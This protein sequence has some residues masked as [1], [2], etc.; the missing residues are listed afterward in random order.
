[1]DY[2]VDPLVYHTV[3]DPQWLDSHRFWY[4]DL[5]PDGVTYTLVDTAKRSKAPAFDHAKIAAALEAAQ[6]T[7]KLSLPANTRLDPA[8]LPIDDLSI[9]DGDHT[10]V[11]TIGAKRIRCELRDQ[12]VCKSAGDVL[13][14]TFDVAPDG[15]TA[16]FIRDNNLWVRD[17][18]TGRETQLTQDG[19]AD[20]GYATDNAGWTRSGRPILVWSPDSKKIATYRQDQRKVGWLYLTTTAVGHPQLEAW[21]SPLPGDE[22]ITTIQRV[23]IDVA[24]RKVI[25]LKMPP[26]LHR[27]SLCDDVSCA[28]GHGWDDVQ[29]SADSTQLAFVSTSR[30]HKQETLRVADAATGDVRDALSETAQTYFESGDGALN[31]RYLSRSNEAL[32][33]SQRDNWG[34]LYLYDLSTGRLKNPVTKGDGNV[35][36]VL[37][38]DEDARRIYFLGAGKEAGRDPYFTTVYRVNF[39]G[40]GMQLLTPEAA[41][42]DVTMSPDG[43][44]FVDIASMPT[45]PQITLVRDSEGSTVMPVA[46]QD[47]TKL[48]DLGWQPPMPITVKAR[49]GKTDLYGLLFRPT[50]FDPAKRYPVVDWVYPG[51]QAGSCDARSFSPARRDL[52]ALAELGFVVVC[53]DGLGTNMRSKAFHDALYG[54]MGDNT[55]PDQVAGIRQLAARYPWIDATRA[56]IY[57]HSGGGAAAAAAMFH[58]PDFFK[59]GIAESGNHDN[60]LYEDDWAEKWIGLLKKNPDGTT[61]Y[62]S[63]A[64]ENYAAN[65][66]G[67]LLLVHGTMDENVPPNSTLLVV[68]ALVK[69]NK[70]FDLLMVPNEGHDYREAKPYVRRRR[71]DYFVRWLADGTPPVDYSMKPWAEESEA[72]ARAGVP[73]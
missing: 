23:V 48:R 68:D 3:R 9:E 14:D 45:T 67:H 43:R 8:H 27:S 38:V 39:D 62:D 25:R 1:M 7:G 54:D 41:N 44:V 37:H 34:Q 5:G 49:D 64:N 31:W 11:L 56:G 13:P 4:R 21:R 55:I 70:D 26:D 60:R 32:W 58:F 69:A 36:Q 15:R 29:W 52:G 24:A 65:L 57:G 10:V 16:A 28:G 53:I 66:K 71:W 51:P 46:Q 2:N 42:H 30:D 50:A 35:T 19:Q 72:L 18:A 47:I 33:F 63:Q 6:H 17:I 73:Q 12:P 40:T 61:N 20:F 59:A 22:N